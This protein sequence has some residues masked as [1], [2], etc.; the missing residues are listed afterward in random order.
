MATRFWEVTVSDRMVELTDSLYFLKMAIVSRKDVKDLGDQWKC[1]GIYVL[2]DGWADSWCAYIGKGT[3]LS[4]RIPNNRDFE[5]NRALIVRRSEPFDSAEIGWLE[6]RI[7]ELLKAAGVELENKQQPRDDTLSVARQ[8]ILENYV[9]VIQHALVLL[10]YDPA[11]QQQVPAQTVELEPEDARPATIGKAHRNV[12]D[13]VRAGTQIESTL[14][15]HPAT[16]TVES[17]GIRYQGNLYGSL[18]AAAKVVTGYNNPDGWSSWGVRSDSGE[19]VSLKRLRTQTSNR[20]SAV[21]DARNARSV[22]DSDEQDRMQSP[23]RNARSKTTPKKMSAARVNDFLA[24][25][26]EGATYPQLE[27][28]FGLTKG[29]IYKLLLENGRVKERRPSRTRQAR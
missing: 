24:R 8:K 21:R 27:K 2:V 13:V 20:T 6:G 14:R 3:Q 17:T 9:V 4:V 26:D 5:W 19:V 15:K 12:L 25:K 16:A 11:G 28:E 1:P 7:I 22:T 23:R 10:G 29:S 18:Q